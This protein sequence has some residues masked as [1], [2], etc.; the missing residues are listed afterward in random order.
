MMRFRYSYLR[1]G[2]QGDLTWKTLD[3]QF[4]S[5]KVHSGLEI[6]LRGNNAVKG[7]IPAVIFALRIAGWPYACCLQPCT[8]IPFFL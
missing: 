4:G 5:L 3:L 7:T 6:Q 2:D 1:H 8:L